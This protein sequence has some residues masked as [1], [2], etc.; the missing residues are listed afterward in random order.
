MSSCLFFGRILGSTGGWPDDELANTAKAHVG[1]VVFNQ[2]GQVLL[3]EP[4]NHFDGYVWTFP[5]IRRRANESL[6]VTALRATKEKGG[7]EPVTVDHLDHTYGGTAGGS[8]SFYSVMVHNDRQSIP[9]SSHVASTIW[10]KPDEARGL[11]KKTAILRGGIETCS[12][13]GVRLR[14]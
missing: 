13:S 9:T 2:A 10:A 1:G 4:K 14:S 12:F 5:K 7:V 8:M 3:I 6:D 11:I